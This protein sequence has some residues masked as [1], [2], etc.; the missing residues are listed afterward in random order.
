MHTGDLAAIHDDGY[1]NT[2][3]RT[4]DLV[5]RGGENA[6]PRARG[7][8]LHHPAVADVQVVGVPDEKYGEELCAWVR[9]RDADTNTEENIREFCRSK[10]ARFKV[11]RYVVFVDD[12]YNDGHRQGPQGG[13]ARDLDREARSAGCR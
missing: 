8:P 6:Y 13:D 9:L 3:G 1:V 7:V 4:K 10:L 5:I 12:I 11:P 2:V